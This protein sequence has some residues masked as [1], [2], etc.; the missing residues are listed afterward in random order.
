MKAFLDTNVLVSA[1]TTRGLCADVL[2]ATLAE[3]TLITG[4]VVLEA[5]ERVLATRFRVPRRTIADI[6]A[7]IGQYAQVTPRPTTAAPIKLRDE[8]D[9]WTIASA[10]SADAEVLVTGDRELL[11]LKSVAHL[12]IIGPRDFWELSQQ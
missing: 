7:L 4:E 1:F 9:T 12:G 2:R 6:K 5:L 3:H 8:D 10:L 11:R